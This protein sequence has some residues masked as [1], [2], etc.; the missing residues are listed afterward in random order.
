M[1]H[2]S[3]LLAATLLSGCRP[4]DSSSVKRPGEPDMISVTADDAAMNEAIS[5]ARATL[6]AFQ[7]VLAAP[8]PGSSSF[9]VKVAFAYGKDGGAEH[10]WLTEPQFTG[11]NVSGLINNEPVDVTH[12]KLGQRVT[13]PVTDISDWM[14][15]QNDVLKGGE[16][17]R[18][19]LN[20]MPPEERA[21]TLRSMG[22]R[23]E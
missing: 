12:L 14:Y 16:T 3:L 10:I 15:S 5:K 21:E 13:A 22:L 1:R 6:P 11:E 9:A 20:R 17:V 8:P 19:L 23:L 18:T 7:A 2:L 4:S